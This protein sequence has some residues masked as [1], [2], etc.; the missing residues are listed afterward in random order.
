MSAMGQISHT[1]IQA[2]VFEFA[3]IDLVFSKRASF[4]P[5]WTVDS[6]A[7][8]LIWLALNC[9]LPGDRESLEL[10][11]DALGTH[12]TT[13]MRRIF[14]ERTLSDLDVRLIADPADENVLIFPGSGGRQIT[15]DEA[16]Q[17]L[18]KVGLTERVPIDRTYWQVHDAMILIPWKSQESDI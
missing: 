8:F 14:F 15:K 1:Q 3:L 12:L 18:E 5:L 10:F 13:K 16:N 17:T 4:Q 6:W 7:K 11:A 9:G 2:K